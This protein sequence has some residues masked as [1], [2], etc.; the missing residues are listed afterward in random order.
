M[1]GTGYKIRKTSKGHVIA[2]FSFFAWSRGIDPA[3]QNTKAV[4]FQSKRE[5]YHGHFRLKTFDVISI[6]PK[7]IPVQ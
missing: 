2:M 7:I 6:C 1:E 3:Q 5:V 4:V